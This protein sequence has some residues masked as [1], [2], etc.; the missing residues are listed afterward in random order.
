MNDSNR[1]NRTIESEDKKII[2][3]FAIIYPIQTILTLVTNLI[4]CWL[5]YKTKRL[6]TPGNMILVS[7]CI[8]GMLQTIV[9]VLKT[10]FTFSKDEDV[11]KIVHP[12]L[13]Y[14]AIITQAHLIILSIDRLFAITF[15]LRYIKW[16]TVK[17]AVIAA[18]VVWVIGLFLIFAISYN[19]EEGKFWKGMA[20]CSRNRSLRKTPHKKT[21]MVVKY[22]CIYFLPL[23]IIVISYTISFRIALSQVKEIFPMTEHNMRKKSALKAARTTA[24]LIGTYFI[25]YTPSYV[26]VIVH[27]LRNRGPGYGPCN[28]GYY[29]RLI[30]SNIWLAAAWI[31][32]LVYT[33]TNA[34]FKETLLKLFKRC[35]VKPVHS[36]SAD[37]SNDSKRGK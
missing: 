14:I 11:C 20:H 37:L 9:F 8:C 21:N 15:P 2:V 19:G 7:L 22:S 35:G 36:H 28:T 18:V 26:S 24:I 10:I 31:N 23:T 34:D 27:K 32:P 3:I 16:V 29:V 4:V 1:C 30:T 17:G 33:M 25:L 12:L 13:K 5:V 6:R